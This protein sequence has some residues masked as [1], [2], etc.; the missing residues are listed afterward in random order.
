M[1]TEKII[2]EVV[3]MIMADFDELKEKLNTVVSK[4]DKDYKTGKL[5]I[6][7]DQWFN[8]IVLT[9]ALSNHK[10][11]MINDYM[12]RIKHSE[13]YTGKVKE[14]IKIATKFRDLDFS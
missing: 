9:G 4:I 1:E 14:L 3:D 12:D 6:S 2:D 7:D 13:A 8:I 11:G 5:I 10:V